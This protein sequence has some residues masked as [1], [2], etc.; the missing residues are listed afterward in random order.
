MKWLCVFAL[1][2]NM[3]LL[4]YSGFAF[5][6]VPVSEVEKHKVKLR[7]AINEME[8]QQTGGRSESVAPDASS[9]VPDEDEEVGEPAA[10][11]EE[12]A[13]VPE[14][15]EGAMGVEGRPT[16]DIDHEA[17]PY[18]SID[19]TK[20]GVEEAKRTMRKSPFR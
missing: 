10:G 9:P 4:A 2:V 15:L 3:L 13:D 12:P 5:I 7:T 6:T 20:E 18:G 14:G 16:Y 8:V 11:A 1:V 19:R 17:D